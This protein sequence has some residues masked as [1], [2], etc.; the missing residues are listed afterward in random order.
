MKLIVYIGLKDAILDPQGEAISNSLNTL[1]FE[2]IKSVR[3]GKT[4]E[5][6]LEETDKKRA[7]ELVSKMCDM[8]LVN[9]TIENFSI[10]EPC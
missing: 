3:Q 1:G 2:N 10:G 8:L 7:V 9:N 6:D 4:I 5:L